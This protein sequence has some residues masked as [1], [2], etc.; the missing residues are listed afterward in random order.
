M[1][2]GHSYVK[3]L[4]RFKSLDEVQVSYFTLFKFQSHPI[5]LK[6]PVGTTVVVLVHT[7]GYQRIPIPVH[8]NSTD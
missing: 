2:L 3:L 6:T 8:Y 7:A 1:E 5:C 4:T